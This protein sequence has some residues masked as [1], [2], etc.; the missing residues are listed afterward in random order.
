MIRWCLFY[1]SDPSY[2]FN[3]AALILLFFLVFLL[4]LKQ[5]YP[6]KKSR[7]FQ[8]MVFLAFFSTGS[9]TGSLY[10]YLIHKTNFNVIYNFLYLLY[11]VTYSS[12]F[13]TYFS[14]ITQITED[15]IKHS[16]SRITF[17]TS[18]FLL[19]ILTILTPFIGF[20]SDSVCDYHSGLLYFIWHAV[21]I[22]LTFTLLLKLSIS[23]QKHNH[24]LLFSTFFLLMATILVMLIQYIHPTLFLSNFTIAI[25][26]FF[27]YFT[28][29]NSE[30]YIDKYLNCYNNKAF[31]EYVQMNQRK[32]KSFS[33]L[34]I[35]FDE[36]T[37]IDQ[38]IGADI[39]DTII[40]DLKNYLT[41]TYGRKN[42]YALYNIGFAMF[43]D[44][45][46]ETVEK[47][48]KTI[49]DYFN[50]AFH[51]GTN[52]ENLTPI[53]CIVKDPSFAQNGHQL[54]D[55]VNNC[56]HEMKKNKSGMVTYATGKYLAIVQREQQVIHAMKKAIKYDTFE[57]YYQPIFDI[58]SQRVRSMEALLRLKDE[59]LGF[60]P[61]D[62]FIVIAEKN[63]MIIDISEIAFRKVC[64]FIHDYNIKSLG[65]DYIEYNLSIV[66]CDNQA[67]A[68]NLLAIM[69]EYDVD[70]AQIN[71]EITETAQAYNLNDLTRNMEVLIHAGSTFSM[72]DYGTGYSTT[73][74]LIHLPL[75]IVK[76]DKSI[77]WPAMKD[78]KSYNVLSQLVAT[79]KSIEK[80]IVVEGVETEEM[81]S[82][83]EKLNCDYLQGYYY[84][85]PVPAD[86]IIKYLL[87]MQPV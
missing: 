62:E 56:F 26:L 64:A 73:Q 29:N 44:N 48:M 8:L 35:Q 49:Q 22:L 72:D 59:E 37:Y 16:F 32:N 2:E 76:I 83:L 46:Q 84:S 68:P 3:I 71:F 15:G 69:K 38:V 85:K 80:K 42:V 53:F 52:T 55:E 66:E 18:I 24:L 7:I 86:E 82:L 9:E 67:L 41:H 50:K 77:L 13:V 6:N 27:L 74:Y 5:I 4:L 1:M 10:L 63:G 34:A 33:V 36:Y 65:I 39:L 19:V 78:E 81:V 54:I 79:L 57:V 30:T 75:H 21:P 23:D 40:K 61:P 31:I 28:L 43:L 17:F 70:P 51:L 12:T 25:F 87:R 14:Y 60:I 58:K 45:K 47:T 11:L 20:S